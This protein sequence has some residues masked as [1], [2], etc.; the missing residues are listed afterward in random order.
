MKNKEE[1]E[2]VR[3]GC[4]TLIEF[5]PTSLDDRKRLELIEEVL[6]WVIEQ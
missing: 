5:D 3:G 4:R 2:T 1:L 6:D